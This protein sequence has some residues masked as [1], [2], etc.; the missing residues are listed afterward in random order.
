M[1]TAIVML[2]KVGLTIWTAAMQSAI[3]NVLATAA[4]GIGEERSAPTES[5][6]MTAA[7]RMTATPP[8]ISASTFGGISNGKAD[9]ASP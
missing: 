1:Q 5:T 4:A 9:Q 6:T 8:V 7:R 2:K 3:G